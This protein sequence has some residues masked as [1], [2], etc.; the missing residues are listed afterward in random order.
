MAPGAG[1]GSLGT[2][3][4]HMSYSPNSLHGGSIR[5]YIGHYSRGHE[6]GY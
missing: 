6:G 2:L 4:G 3:G 1:L 5:D